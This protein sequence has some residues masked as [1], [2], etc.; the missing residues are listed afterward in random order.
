MNGK[1]HLVHY[2]V[3]RDKIFIPLMTFVEKHEGRPIF[4]IST[5][6]C[7]FSIPSNKKL[8]SSEKQILLQFAKP[9]YT[10]SEIAIYDISGRLLHR[11]NNE[12]ETSLAIPVAQ[13]GIYIIR[14]ANEADVMSKK[15][16][17]D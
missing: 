14:V 9:E 4:V 7:I 8:F 11:I 17:V 16:F 5:L 6:L 3:I 15:L 10:N 2:I 12:T 1:F 13:T